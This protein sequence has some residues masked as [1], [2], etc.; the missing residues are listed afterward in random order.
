MPE[1]SLK[2]DSSTGIFLRI[3]PNLTLFTENIRVTVPADCLV[4][5]SF[6]Q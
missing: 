5:T 3:L 1:I 4:S 2:I 6:I